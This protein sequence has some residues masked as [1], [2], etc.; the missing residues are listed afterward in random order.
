MIVFKMLKK[1]LIGIVLVFPALSWA[2][3]TDKQQNANIVANSAS[4]NYK[5]HICIYRGN[6]KL[7]QGS[8]VLTA[9]VLTT[10]ANAKN[11]LQKAIAV[12]KLASYTTLPD[13]SPLP[14][15]AVAETINYYPLQSQIYLIGQAKATQGNDSF[16]GYQINYNTKLQSISTPAT[17]HE[18]TTIVF[19]PTQKVNL[20]Q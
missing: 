10:F 3:T 16:A 17:P 2:L 9:D 4:I 1:L 7:T 14:F 5:K 8:T 18:R 20:P 13:N 19:Q 11:Q 12:G 6:V 15:A